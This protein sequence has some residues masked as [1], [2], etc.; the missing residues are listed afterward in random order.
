MNLNF[1]ILRGKLHF[2]VLFIV[3]SGVIDF[4]AKSYSALEKIL[5][6][7]GF[8]PPAIDFICGHSLRQSVASGNVIFLKYLDP[9][10][11]QRVIWFFPKYL[12][13]LYW[14]LPVSEGSRASS[15]RV[16]QSP[17][18][19]RPSFIEMRKQI[20]GAERD[21]QTDRPTD[22]RTT[23][24]SFFLCFD[25]PPEKCLTYTFFFKMQ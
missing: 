2:D 24:L 7:S 18:I 13:R 23:F 21:R 20:R 5:E 12:K 1:L 8:G 9:T 17:P 15:V 11:H 19:N 4:F 16:F 22:R 25:G 3:G 6:V 10:A 14:A